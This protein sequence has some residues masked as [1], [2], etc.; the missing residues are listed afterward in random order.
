[1]RSLSFLRLVTWY[2]M[3]PKASDA[4]VEY[5]ER[6]D[7]KKPLPEHEKGIDELMKQQPTPYVANHQLWSGYVLLMTSIKISFSDTSRF[8]TERQKFIRCIAAYSKSLPSGYGNCYFR[9]IEFTKNHIWT[10]KHQKDVIV[11]GPRI[12]MSISIFQEASLRWTTFIRYLCI[13]P[14]CFCRLL[15]WSY[16]LLVTI[17]KI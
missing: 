1:M 2:C 7:F 3:R 14:L 5:W 10:S 11:L 17:I 6:E 4:S 16:K 12:K 8:E 13:V 9:P 15:F